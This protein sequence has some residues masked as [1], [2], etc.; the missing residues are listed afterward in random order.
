MYHAACVRE[1]IVELL[2]FDVKHSPHGSCCLNSLLISP[3]DVILVAFKI[4]VTIHELLFVLALLFWIV[5]SPD[6]LFVRLFL[7][8]ISKLRVAKP[9]LVVRAF[10][11]NV[12]THSTW[13]EKT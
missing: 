9:D 2:L 12:G 1:F 8:R 4:L 3:S 11:S 10:C 5:N 7:D 13:R 6:Q